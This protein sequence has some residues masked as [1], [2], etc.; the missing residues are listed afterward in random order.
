MI[1]NYIFIV[2]TVF[3]QCEKIFESKS[4]SNMVQFKYSTYQAL[5]AGL[6]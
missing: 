3:N 2:V 1:I 6:L 4:V 5:H